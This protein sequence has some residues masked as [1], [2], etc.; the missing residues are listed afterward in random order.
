LNLIRLDIMWY[1]IKLRPSIPSRGTLAELSLQVKEKPY[2][3]GR[4][5]LQQMKDAQ[6]I[7]TSGF[8]QTAEER[9]HLSS[10][11]FSR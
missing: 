10:A 9:A 2:I 3:D 8:L 4:T 7:I 1:A 6:D 5:L 11:F